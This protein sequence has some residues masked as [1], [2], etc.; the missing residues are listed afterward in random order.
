[1]VDRDVDAGTDPIGRDLPGPPAQRGRPPR[2][3]RKRWDRTG[4][5][6]GKEWAERPVGRREDGRSERAR[7]LRQFVRDLLDSRDRALD[8]GLSR[9]PA[10]GEVLLPGLRILRD[11]RDDLDELIAATVAE[12][13]DAGATWDD[14]AERLAPDSPGPVPGH[15]VKAAPPARGSRYYKKYAARIGMLRD[16]AAAERHTRI[17]SSSQM[18]PPLML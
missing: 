3:P 16:Q 8:D 10:P 9:T 14:I 4:W 17:Q 6:G 1:M 2:P 15:P 11:L 13:Y 5:F 12:A 7:R 18:V